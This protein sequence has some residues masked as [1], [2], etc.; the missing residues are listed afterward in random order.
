MSVSEEV[1][2]TYYEVDHDELLEDI[3]DA[4]ETREPLYIWGRTGIGKSYTVREAARRLAEKFGRKYSERP[5]DA[6]SEHFV[7]V[8]RRLAQMEPTDLLG[9]LYKDNG[10]SKWHYPDW[11]VRLTKQWEEQQGVEVKGILFFD[12]LNL[13]SQIIQN[14]AYSIINERRIHELELAD[15]VTVIAAGN[16]AEDK[17]YT[18][19]LADPLKTRFTH[20]T[21]KIPVFKDEESRKGW[22]YWAAEKGID[23]RI[24]AFL[25]FR[26]DLLFRYIENDRTF[27]TPRGWEKASRLMKRKSNEEA[28]RAVAKA[29]GYAAG[30][31]FKEFMELSADIDIDEVLKKPEMFLDFDIS[32][33]FS[34]IASLS[35]LYTQKPDRYAE[36]MM[37]LAAHL[38]TGIYDD[39]KLNEYIRLA[40]KY[41]GTAK[42]S[43]DEMEKIRRKMREMEGERQA[44]LAALILSSM[45][46]VN[47]EKFS[48]VLFKSKY[49]TAV[50]DLVYY[51]I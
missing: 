24:L 49:S 1:G 6:D 31:Q 46:D 17:A 41:A 25:S 32:V 19:D 28:W 20:V 2:S 27:P 9:V 51:T 4:Y 16:V 43:E 40:E 35:H 12:E 8:D 26:P 22:Y 7:L 29:C 10:V 45:K 37:K 30:L 38:F 13:A 44:E 14:A 18:F 47:R 21:L 50:V 15:G 33:R 5:E 39:R 34:V 23:G 48:E 11:L 36:R 3:I 42:E